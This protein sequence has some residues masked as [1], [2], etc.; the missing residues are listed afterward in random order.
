MAGA[1]LLAAVAGLSTG[2]REVTETAPAGYEPA[3]VETVAGREVKR[4]TFTDEAVKRVGLRTAPVRS[5]GT[6]LVVPY[7]ALIYDGKGTPW[8]YTASTPLSYLRTKVVVDRI[9]GNR[10]FLAKGPPAGSQVVTIGATEV[11][12]AELEISGGH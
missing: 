2:C 11:Y 3:A 10:A 4:V 8:V 12:G 9:D 1:L 7:A 6:R 5:S